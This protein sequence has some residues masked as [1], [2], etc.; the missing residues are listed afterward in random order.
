[1]HT[2]QLGST[3]CFWL[4]SSFTCWIANLSTSKTT[5]DLSGVC[6]RLIYLGHNSTF[7]SQ[8]TVQHCF[9]LSAASALNHFMLLEGTAHS[10]DENVQFSGVLD[11][12]R[13]IFF[14]KNKI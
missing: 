3:L 9:V 5:Q 4:L 2:W 11:L 10:S 12:K 6:V 8:L 1:M 14:F 7:S 13:F